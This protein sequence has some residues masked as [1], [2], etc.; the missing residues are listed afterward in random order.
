MGLSGYLKFSSDADLSRLSKSALSFLS[1]LG[2]GGG[3]GGGWCLFVA[4]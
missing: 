2:G 3:G 1:F 4:L